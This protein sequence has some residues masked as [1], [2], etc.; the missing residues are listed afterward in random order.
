LKTS[1]SASSQ[2]PAPARTEHSAWS[3][4]QNALF[5]S[6]WIAT[7]VSNVG[8]WMQDVGAGWLMTSLSSSPSMVALVEAA[9][10]FPVMLLALPAGAL[11]DIVDRRRLLIAIQIY[12]LVV[13][14]TLGLLTL[15]E[16]MTAWLLLAFTFALGVGAAMMMPAWAAIV[17]DL[18]PTDEMPSAI[19]LNSVAINVSRAIGPAIA[20]VLVAAVGAWLV[21]LLNAVSYVGILAVL[22]RWRR[23]HHK[24][25]LPA[26]RFLSAIRVGMRFVMHTYALQV[27]L[28][29]GSAFF[30]FAAATWSLFPLIVRQE[31]GRGPEIYGFLLTCIGIGAV[32]G[33]VLLPRVRAKISRDALVAGA[34]ALY[35][36]AALA[37]AHLHNVGLLA[38]AMLATGVAW[39]AILS[40]LQ[41]AAQMTLPAW[42]RARG[43]A[44]FVVV[45]MGGMALG[46]ILWGQV[47]TR[48]GIP[49]TLTTAALGMVLAIGLTRRF[50]LGH[51]AVLDF[52]PSMDWAAPV[53]AEI[54][55]PDSGPV[56]V[57]IEYQVQP[58]KRAEFVTAMQAVREM[59]RRNGAYFWELFHDSADTAH[60]VEC[61]MDESWLEHL[62]QHERVSVADRA[63]QQRA[64]QFLV[65][66]ESTKSSHW[67]ADRET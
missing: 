4:L 43:L 32:A 63:I 52:S 62:R 28:I 12:L 45:F 56:M 8:T 59:R 36:L 55:E 44:A 47:A 64:K 35:A 11:A 51:H 13:A 6:L 26:E 22:L 60:F 17:P 41:V 57:T 25:T 46:S 3:P 21:F 49:A 53:L 42:V 38:V 9:D 48:I 18:V 16:M 19:A 61:F 54:P 66:G 5:R 37:L 67:L 24:S 7:I 23:E 30:V 20:G 1:P 27:V 40:A 39:I 15:L 29:R 10:S 14:G 2:V 50:K 65:E 31:L 33:A 58:T 34:S